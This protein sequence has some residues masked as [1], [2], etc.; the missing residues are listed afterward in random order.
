[1]RVPCGGPCWGGRRQDLRSLPPLARVV[2]TDST[3]FWLR[4][5]PVHLAVCGKHVGVVGPSM[6]VQDCC[7]PVHGCY[8]ASGCCHVQGHGCYGREADMGCV[9][10]SYCAP[11]GR[12]AKGGVRK[13]YSPQALATSTPGV[14]EPTGPHAGDKGRRLPN[15]LLSRGICRNQM[16]GTRR[17]KSA[18][19]VPWAGILQT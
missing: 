9:A 5:W 6:A 8:G 18:H 19:G 1:M 3:A 12:N 4:G 11:V 16:P 2:A 14:L 10:A 15:G 7:G 13:P 17:R